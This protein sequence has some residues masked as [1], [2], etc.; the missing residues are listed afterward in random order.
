MSGQRRVVR[1]KAY[2]A[3]IPSEDC[4]VE[5]AEPTP[6]L[7]D[8]QVLV[9]VLYLGMDPFSRMR[10]GGDAAKAPQVPL[11]AVMVARG[12]GRV[13]QSR[14]PDLK[15]GDIIA[16]DL[17]WTDW[18]VV[19]GAGLRKV[20]PALGPVRHALG[21]LGPSGLAAWSALFDRGQAKA[22]ETV[23]ISAAAGAV[24]S[25][26][27]QL[28]KQKGCRVIGV[29]G[30]AAQLAFLRDELKLD[31]V[32]DFLSAEPMSAQIRAYAPAGV[33]LFLDMV[34]GELYDHAIQTLAIHGRVVLVGTIAN[35]NDAAGAADIGPRSNLTIILKRA[36]VLGFLVADH[37]A[38]FDEA[39]TELAEGVAS[40]A[41]LAPERILKGLEN[42]PAAFAG[43]FGAEFIGKQLVQINPE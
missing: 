35:Y 32:V 11:G 3:G 34:G 41:L 25:V 23:L 5:T 38:R 9:E 39:L 13:S 30:G 28:A 16:G 33:D 21:I 17:G 1:L 12:V 40:G 26:A 37:A 7:A 2:A 10:I 8:G 18:A 22:G 31:G 29:G 24:G 43:L 19:E 36:T 20:D 4:F 14:A 27:A 15:P 6:A 42:A